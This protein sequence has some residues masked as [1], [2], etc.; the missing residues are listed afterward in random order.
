MNRTILY[1]NIP[2]PLE[3]AVNNIVNNPWSLRL[4]CEFHD[5][6]K[7]LF[8]KNNLYSRKPKLFHM[9]YVNPSRGMV[10]R[11]SLVYDRRLFFM[12][13]DD[14]YAKINTGDIYEYVSVHRLTGARSA[15]ILQSDRLFPRDVL[16][17]FRYLP[18][19]Y[20]YRITA[21][22]ERS[23]IKEIHKDIVLLDDMLNM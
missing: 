6:G 2:V 5:I 15:L 13:Q 9:Q 19:K 18:Q 8:V 23:G 14:M 1:Q 7:K 3:K 20:P 10:R 4:A 16:D 12:G 21:Y 22:K 11:A 17:L